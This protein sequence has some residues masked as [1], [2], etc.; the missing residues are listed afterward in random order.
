MFGLEDTFPGGFDNGDQ[1]LESALGEWL[2]RYRPEPHQSDSQ[3]DGLESSSVQRLFDHHPGNF[4]TQPIYMSPNARIPYEPALRMDV[5]SNRTL[6][7]MVQDWQDLIDRGDDGFAL[8][9]P[10]FHELMSELVGRGLLSVDWRW[11]VDVDSIDMGYAGV[12]GE[13]LDV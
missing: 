11:A 7:S 6:I 9:S 3:L 2:Q 4:D 10:Q 8:Q 12:M 1:Q 5:L 13:G